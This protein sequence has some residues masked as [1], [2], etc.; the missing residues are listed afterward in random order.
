LTEKIDPEYEDFLFDKLSDTNH[1][2]DF[3]EYVEKGGELTPEMR[4]ILGQLI[5]K[6]MPQPR[7]NTNRKRDIDAYCDVEEWRR[8][9]A[10]NKLNVGGDATKSEDAGKNSKTI[11]KKSLAVATIEDFEAIDGAISQNLPTLQKA[12]QH[13]TSDEEDAEINIEAYQ[14]Q[15]ER[16]RKILWGYTASSHI[17]GNK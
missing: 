17:D 12:F 6:R 8:E 15:Y 5:R 7:G 13:F 3:A 16:G 11:N 9:F 1:P 10:L 4:T 14:K 2:Y